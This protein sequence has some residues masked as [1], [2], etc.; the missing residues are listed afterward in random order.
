MTEP[1]HTTDPWRPE[2]D[3]PTVAG[4]YWMHKQGADVVLVHISEWKA[5][6]VHWRKSNSRFR[7][8]IDS[9][10]VIDA[11]KPPTQQEATPPTTPPNPDAPTITDP[12][13]TQ[14]L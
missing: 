14:L 7:W 13:V 12:T 3:V 4:H 8:S 5:N 1:Q 10:P 2:G 9:V 11:P 6:N